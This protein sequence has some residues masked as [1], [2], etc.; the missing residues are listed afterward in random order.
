MGM[1]SS[2]TGDAKKDAA[3]FAKEATE[4]IKK[5][6]S[7]VEKESMGSVDL[8][9]DMPELLRY[10]NIL[11][12]AATHCNALQHTCQCRDGVDGQCRLG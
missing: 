10:C 11:Q 12:H 4:A 1:T 8:G 9:D 2:S 5:G 7:N 6:V 3:V